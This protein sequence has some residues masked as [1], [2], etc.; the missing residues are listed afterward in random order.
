M[1]SDTWADKQGFERGKS[2]GRDKYY[3]LITCETGSGIRFE[4]I[5]RLVESDQTKLG[6]DVSHYEGKEE[7][8]MILQGLLEALE[9]RES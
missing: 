8:R 2:G 7:F 6:I 3:Q 4:F 9:G 1:R 5:L